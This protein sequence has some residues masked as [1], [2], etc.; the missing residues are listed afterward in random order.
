MHIEYKKGTPMLLTELL[1]GGG[2]EDGG[3]SFCFYM[4]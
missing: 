4:L 2:C 1:G 3:T